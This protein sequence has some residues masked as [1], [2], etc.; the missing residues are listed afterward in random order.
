MSDKKKNENKKAEVFGLTRN[1]K[2][3]KNVPDDLKWAIPLVEYQDTP[4]FKKEAAE[5]KKRVMAELLE[6][7]RKS[8]KLV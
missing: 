1:N 6:E 7:R 5:R 4:E 2:K 8:F 3:Y